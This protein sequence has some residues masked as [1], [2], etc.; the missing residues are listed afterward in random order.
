M[1]EY[2]DLKR[3][4]LTK[5]EAEKS[6]LR[7]DMVSALREGAT[8][9]FKEAATKAVEAKLID[10]KGL[11]EVIADAR[12]GPIAHSFQQLPLEWALKTYQ[13]ANPDERKIMG[14]ILIKKMGNTPMVE[15]ARIVGL[16]KET[17]K[18]PNADGG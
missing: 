8:I 17:F 5:T 16:I 11:T 7:R 1:A 2:A 6:D 13:L 10:I 4:T 18:K 3:G 9:E 15:K 14:P 12:K